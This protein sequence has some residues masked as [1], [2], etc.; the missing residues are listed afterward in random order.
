MVHVS[1]FDR[2]RTKKD[3]S[4]SGC[5]SL[6]R[7]G[8]YRLFQRVKKI[9]RNGTVLGEIALGRHRSGSIFVISQGGPLVSSSQGP[10]Y[11]IRYK[12]QC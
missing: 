11:D 7:I 4:I 2:G 9:F 10:Q 12:R 5:G 8:I 6:D 3:R 1:V